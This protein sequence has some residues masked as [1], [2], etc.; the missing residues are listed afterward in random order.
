LERRFFVPELEEVEVGEAIL[1]SFDIETIEL[2]TVLFQNGL[3]HHQGDS[4][5]RPKAQ[6]SPWISQS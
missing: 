6:I 1:E 4:K 2:E 5:T 3:S